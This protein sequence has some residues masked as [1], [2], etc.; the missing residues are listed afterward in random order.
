MSGDKVFVRG[1]RVSCRIGVSPGERAAPRT[2]ALDVDLFA[3]GRFAAAAL[4]AGEPP[5]DYAQV[6]ECLRDLA[7]EREFDLLENFVEA[8][9]A[10]LLARFPVRAARIACAKPGILPAVDSVGVEIF[11]RAGQYGE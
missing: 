5:I 6:V 2:I 1:L 9:A 11:R 10:I 3:R 7:A 8:A 4:R